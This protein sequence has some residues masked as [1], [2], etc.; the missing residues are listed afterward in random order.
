LFF[1]LLLVV[2]SG[3]IVIG[4]AGI[5]NQLFDLNN[6]RLLAI[7]FLLPVLF[8]IR[9]FD[10]R[11]VGVFTMP[12]WLV[13]GYVL[14]ST[15]LTYRSSEATV[16]GVMRTGTVFA[17]D[18]LIPYFAFSRTV[19]SVADFRKVLCAFVIAVL[20]LSLIAVFELVKRWH[21]YY[22]LAASWGTEPWYLER[23]GLLRASAS[24]IDSICMGFIIMVAVGCLLAIWQVIRS[25]QVKG[26]VSVIFVTGIIATLARGPWVGVAILLLVYVAMGSNAIANLGKVAVIGAVG[27]A[28]LLVTPLG[29]RLI[30]FLPFVGTVGE[31]G[32][33]YRQKLFDNSL[34]VIQRSPLFG[35]PDFRR[36]PE[37]QQMAQGEH[38]I[39]IVNTYL[40]IA[41]RSGLVGLS[42][43][44]GIFATI[45]LRLRRVLKFHDVNDLNFKACVRALIATLMAMLVTIATVSSVSFIP[46]VYWSFAGLSVALIR[47]GYKERSAAVSTVSAVRAARTVQPVHMLD[48][49]CS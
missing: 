3:K 4:G 23:A 42:L 1:I 8:T 43:F 14:L 25:S 49:R 17:L 12:D 22:P 48:P 30:D 29:T 41:L 21:V 5:V 39:D 19:T 40:E 38:L 36:E 33:T 31:G 18:V 35:S 2:P 20:P 28:M 16:T 7:V 32:V 6:P 15:A 26:I 11:Q 47:I 45:L 13:V 10:R 34:V 37:M 27:L 46:Y 9:G 44:F 24:A